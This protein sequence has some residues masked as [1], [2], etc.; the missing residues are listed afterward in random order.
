MTRVP[1]LCIIV[2]CPV[3]EISEGQAPTTEQIAIAALRKAHFLLEGAPVTRVAAFELWYMNPETLKYLKD[4]PNLQT[5]QINSTYISDQDLRVLEGIKN[6]VNLRLGYNAKLGDAGMAY[7]KGLTQ[8]RQ[9][10][11][12]HTRV[13]DVGIKELKDLSK[14]EELELGRT[15]LTDLGIVSLKHFEKLRILDLSRTNITDLGLEGIENLINLEVLYLNGTRIGD[16]GIKRLQRM[17]K[18]REL[19]LPEAFGDPGLK[20]LTSMNRI[21]KL[22]LTR[23]KVTDSGLGYLVLF[24]D[25][26]ILSLGETSISGTGLRKLGEKIQLTHLRNLN[27][28]STRILNVDLKY[29]SGFPRLEVLNLTDTLVTDQGLSNLTNLPRLREIWLSGTKTT[30]DGIRAFQMQMPNVK[31]H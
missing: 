5:I 27:L 7:V 8:L 4:L 21:E 22:E 30:K 2:L 23:T 25:L 10:E 13:G 29:L 15:L 24:K 17:D 26:E 28:T 16:E 19:W 31:V 14:L 11:L 20:A 1:F 3:L 12:S 6:L 18:L 9:L